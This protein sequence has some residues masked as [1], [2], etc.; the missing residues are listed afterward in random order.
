MRFGTEESR[1][2][3]AEQYAH[4]AP[5]ADAQRLLREI[6]QRTLDLEVFIDNALPQSRERS[7]AL[8]ALD[9]SRMWACNAAVAGGKINEP[10]AADAPV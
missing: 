4:R 3:L 9:E 10:L 7:L 6:R 1:K 2:K 5:D 8:T